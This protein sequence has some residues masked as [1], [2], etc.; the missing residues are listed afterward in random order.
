MFRPAVFILF[1]LLNLFVY[2]VLR[3][4]VVVW[5]RNQQ[6]QRLAL[7]VLCLSIVLINIPLGT[8]FLRESHLILRQVP[9]ILLRIFFYP[10]TAWLATILCFFLLAAPPTMI[11][12]VVRG[13][14]FVGRTIATQLRESRAAA[15]PPAV[16]ASG[17]ALTR[18]TFLT[19]S[20]GL[21]I[22]GIYGVAAYGVYGNLDELDV[23]KEQATPIPYLPRSLEGLTIVQ[24]SDLHV[25]PYIRE[26]D[27]KYLV[28]R[29]NELRPDLVVLTGDILDWSLESLPDAVRG[30]SGIQSSLGVFAVLGNH[31]IY[32]DR[33][34]FSSEHRGGV[35]IV[36]GLES[37]GIRTLRNQVIHLGSGQDRLALMGLDWLGGTPGGRNFYNYQQARTQQQL[38]LMDE[39][40]GPE[41]PRVLLAHHPD[42][43]T[44]AIPFGIGLTLAGHTHGGGQVILGVVNG[45]PLG[46]GVFRFKYLSG[47]YQEQGCSLYVNRGIGYLGIPIRIN[48]PPE[49]SHFKLVSSPAVSSP[50]RES[51]P[52]A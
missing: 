8:F 36:N 23:S 44:D 3:R 51:E 32:S 42:T 1:L 33:Y 12:A 26:K 35:N 20:A 30:L 39:Q 11:W 24:L 27:L 31:D 48:C 25:G 6:H 5:V 34:S 17:P 21:L 37:I 10:S 29:T 16:A 52:R 43:F 46:P 28:S 15:A 18:R 38:A 22:P 14:L 4:A 13:L 40:A 9:P 49:I 7:N 47:L 2:V 41:T 50:T 45:V 19:S